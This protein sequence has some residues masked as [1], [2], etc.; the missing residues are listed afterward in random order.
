MTILETTSYFQCCK[1]G[2]IPLLSVLVTGFLL[3]LV[4]G[5]SFAQDTFAVRNLNKQ[6]WPEAEAKR[7][8]LLATQ[9]VEREFKL[10]HSVH[11]KFTLVL[12]YANDQMDT[13]SGELRLTKWDRSLFTDGVILFSMEQVLT[14]DVRRE[15]MRRT[16]KA[17]DSTVSVDEE[18]DK[19]F[20][21]PIAP[22]SAELPPVSSPRR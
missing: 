21:V 14:P 12:G 5:T 3:L 8:Y 11:P 9:A 20:A 2:N 19:V 13:T 17:A 10:T 16:L 18:K 15:L 7:I 4:A 1:T 6:K 22:M